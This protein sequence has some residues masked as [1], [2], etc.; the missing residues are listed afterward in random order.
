MLSVRGYY[1][2]DMPE[3]RHG[4]PQPSSNKTSKAATNDATINCEKPSFYTGNWFLR[5]FPQSALAL[6]D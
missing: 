5:R 2:L 4:S 6:G 3:E 1:F